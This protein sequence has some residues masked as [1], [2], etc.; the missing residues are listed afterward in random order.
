MQGMIY[1]QLYHKNVSTK[2]PF[3]CKYGTFAKKIVPQNTILLRC[4]AG[5]HKFTHIYQ[6]F[7]ESLLDIVDQC[8]FVELTVAGAK[9]TYMLNCK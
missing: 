4:S 5:R 7:E 8:S 3:E 9:E 1:H 2:F 6:V